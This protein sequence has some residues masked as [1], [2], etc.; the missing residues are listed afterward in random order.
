MDEKTQSVMQ[1]FSRQQLSFRE[2]FPDTFIDESTDYH[3][4]DEFLQKSGF[5]LQTQ[6]DLARITTDMWDSHV[7]NCSSFDEMKRA[8]TDAWIEKQL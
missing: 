2:L 5:P 1:R 3:T 7:K 4:L 6:E 8:A